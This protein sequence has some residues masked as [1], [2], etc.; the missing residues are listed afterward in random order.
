LNNLLRG[1]N[2]RDAKSA[3]WIWFDLLLLI[4]VDLVFAKK[5]VMLTHSLLPKMP[6][7]N[8]SSPRIK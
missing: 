5:I 3:N 2:C 6:S 8:H 7:M 4:L 1:E